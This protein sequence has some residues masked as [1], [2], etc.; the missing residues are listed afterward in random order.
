MAFTA[1]PVEVV[2][3]GAE[4]RDHPGAGGGG[5][6]QR[7]G[8]GCHHDARGGVVADHACHPEFAAVEQRDIECDFEFVR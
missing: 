7:S 6:V 1:R 3:L 5:Q 2:V 4:Q 8:V